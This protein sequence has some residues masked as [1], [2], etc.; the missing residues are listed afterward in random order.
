MLCHICSVM[1][2]QLLHRERTICF[3][4][5]KVNPKMSIII[6]YSPYCVIIFLS[7]FIISPFMLWNA[8]TVPFICGQT[9]L[10]S[11]SGRE[12][13]CMKVYY[14]VIWTSYACAVAELWW[15][16]C[17]VRSLVIP[18]PREQVQ[19]QVEWSWKCLLERM[20]H[21][22]ARYFRDGN[23]CFRAILSLH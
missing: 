2:V 3:T 7:C 13:V 23:G 10:V 9:D 11:R 12:S 16:H 14:I 20:R 1:M 15:L 21:K 6:I 18:A 17:V 5:P 8:K 19:G 22:R 4:S